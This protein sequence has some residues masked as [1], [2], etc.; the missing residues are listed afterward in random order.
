MARDERTKEPRIERMVPVFGI[1]SYDEAVAD[2]ID[3]L[4][5]NLDWEWREAPG[6]PVIMA[7]SRDGVA[8]MLNEHPDSVA[9]VDL[10]LYVTNLEALAQE[11]NERR[12]GSAIIQ[13]EL[14]YEIPTLMI[15]D[16]SGNALRFQ[17]EDTADQEKLR[18]RNVPKMREYIR[19]KLEDGQPLPTPEE[20]R[21][22]VGPVL[23][24][25]IEVLNEFPGYADAH[26]VH[27]ESTE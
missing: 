13:I 18:T 5:F 16:T 4:G 20:V 25:A 15:R 14:P 6:Q 9:G 12:S 23:G 11:W 10:T 24:F 1:A 21:E 8:F 17:P 7:I 2:Y 3:W 19:E 22:A 26:R 27:Q